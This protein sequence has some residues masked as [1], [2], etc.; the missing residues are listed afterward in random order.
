MIV[1]KTPLRISFAGGG[2]DMDYFYKDEPGAVIT[3]AINKY[4]YIIIN[5]KFDNKI[6]VSY[7]RTEI[8]DKVDD[9]QHELIKECLRFTE[10]E[11]GIEIVSVA[12]IPSGGTG[13][14]SSSAYVVGLLHGLFQFRSMKY[15]IPSEYWH[16]CP[17]DALAHM[18][19]A[20]EID[21]LKKPIGKQDQYIAAYGGFQSF[22]FNADRTV[23]VDPVECL[24]KVQRDLESRLLLF[25]TGIHRNSDTILADQKS[26][27]NKERQ[28]ILREM[29]GIVREM[30][31]AIKLNQLDYFGELLDKNWQLKKRLNGGV[32]NILIDGWYRKAKEAGAIGGK[33]C[34]AGGGGFMLFYAPP[35]SHKAIARSLGF[36]PTSFSFE[37]DGS[38]IVYSE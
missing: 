14:G 10:I 26:R 19:C 30:K 21:R 16:N 33:I 12:D 29:V 35:D 8:V 27:F 7:S 2:S 37:P 18:A 38:R 34:G 4:I 1:T 22:R 25:Y 13:L 11:K 23:D 17:K 15:Q 36:K 5:P 20:V 9:L 31:V 32:S 6:R 3:T 28:G 24:P